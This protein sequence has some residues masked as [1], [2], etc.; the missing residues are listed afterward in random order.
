[1]G[2]AFLLW[3]ITKQVMCVPY[4][5]RVFTSLLNSVVHLLYL[6]FFVCAAVPGSVCNSLPY[7]SI[8]LVQYKE[9]TTGMWAHLDFVICH[10]LVQPEP[11]YS[12]CLLLLHFRPPF[13]V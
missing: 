3:F 4:S 1:M 5:L 7:S 10:P 8:I 11:Q 13:K 2:C 9:T 12:P 6:T